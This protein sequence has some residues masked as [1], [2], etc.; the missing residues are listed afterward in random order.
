MQ[1]KARKK[2]VRRA[3][4]ITKEEI[5]RVIACQKDCLHGL[6]NTALIL[7]GFTMGLRAMEL[8]NLTF[9]NLFNEDW[10]FKKEPWIEDEQTK[11]GYGGGRL[12]NQSKTAQYYI[13]K[14]I[15]QRKSM[16][17]KGENLDLDEPLFS[18]QKGFGKFYPKTVVKLVR[19]IFFKAGIYD[20]GKNKATS[21]SMRRTSA[22]CFAKKGGDMK[23]TMVFLRDRTIGEAQKY[24]EACMRRVELFAT[25]AV[26]K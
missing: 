7:C 14:Y 2:T 5:D 22:T 17:R 18:S 8:A 26:I 24:I 12:F 23:S 21:H 16:L 1:K 19:R 9:R 6:R 13:L 20:D 25:G 15:E 4:I 11:G 10:E 3:R